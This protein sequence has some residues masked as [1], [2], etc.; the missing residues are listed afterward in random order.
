MVLSGDQLYSLLL[1]PRVFV[2]CLFM[3]LQHKS[4]PHS[5]PSKYSGWQC[6]CSRW[7]QFSDDVQAPMLTTPVFTCCCS[8]QL[9]S[10]GV[11]LGRLH[12]FHTF[13]VPLRW[14]FHL[15]FLF[16]RVAALLVST[17]LRVSRLQPHSIGLLPLG[18]ALASCCPR[19]SSREISSSGPLN[20]LP[21]WCQARHVRMP[22]SIPSSAVRLAEAVPARQRTNHFNLGHDIFIG[23]FSSFAQEFISIYISHQAI[24]KYCAFPTIPSKVEIHEWT[25]FIAVILRLGGPATLVGV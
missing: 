5:E 9:L 15:H 1:L 7:A 6:V 3:L 18:C 12:F 14:H 2:M 17:S 8:Q 22:H 4:I 11:A 23:S 19:R 13:H 21:S 24:A 20:R 25:V 16:A 10:T